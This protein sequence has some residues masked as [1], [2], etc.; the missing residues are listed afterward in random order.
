MSE[1]MNIAKTTSLTLMW[2]LIGL[3]FIFCIV[4]LLKNIK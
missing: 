1:I 2:V 4:E 3:F